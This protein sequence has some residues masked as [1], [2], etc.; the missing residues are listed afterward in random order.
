MREKHPCVYILASG[1]NGTLYIGVTSDIYG[2]MALP[3]QKLIPGFTARY[4]VTTLVYYEYH[5]TM[6]DAIRREKQLKEWR[7]LWKLCL[8]E[9][10]N[11]GWHQLFDAATGELTTGPFDPAEFRR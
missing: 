5:Q 2:R 6:A 10:M 4:G 1:P 11:P 9:T 8:I 3:V 7:R